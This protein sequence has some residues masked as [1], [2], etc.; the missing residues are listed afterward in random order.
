MSSA[1]VPLR[2]VQK[3]RPTDEFA[4]RPTS[5]PHA[6]YDRRHDERLRCGRRA[7][8]ARAARSLLPDARLVRGGRGRD[9]GDV[10]ARVARAGGARRRLRPARLAVQDR[11]QR[12]PRRAA[13]LK[14]PAAH[15][16]D[17][18]AAAVPGPPAG[19]D[20]AERGAAGRRRRRARDDRADLHHADP[21]APGAPARGRDPA[22]RARLVRE[23][24]GGAARHERRV[25]QQ[26]A[27]ARA[28][29]AARAAPGA[30]R[31]PGRA[32]RGGAAAARRVHRHARGG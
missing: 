8:P 12:L 31:A 25:G 32:H 6:R 2:A 9:P 26:R 23:R 16:R 17:P 4:S 24:D 11:D 21:A 30:S 28:R 1:F 29:H 19:R 13:P 18:V 7:P 22:R 15:G 10:P 20:R 27:P 3:Q 14:A 5:H